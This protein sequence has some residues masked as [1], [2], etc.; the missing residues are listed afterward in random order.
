MGGTVELLLSCGYA[1]GLLC[2]HSGVGGGC[3]TGYEPSHSS[4]TSHR[5]ELGSACR[6]AV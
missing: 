3:P 6:P 4:L 1:P 5:G 2:T